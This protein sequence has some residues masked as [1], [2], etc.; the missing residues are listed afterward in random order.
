MSSGVINHGLW[1][2]T[3][4]ST[5]CITVDSIQTLQSPPSTIPTLSPK[6]CCTISTVVGLGFPEILALGAAR[7]SQ[8]FC[9]ISSATGCCGI[10]IATNSLPAV[11]ASG[12]LFFLC[13]SMVIGPGMS[14]SIIFCSKGCCMYT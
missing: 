4:A 13:R 3:V 6:F 10:L 11:T 14:V 8:E 2:R 9:S 12:M 1:I 7:A 5:T